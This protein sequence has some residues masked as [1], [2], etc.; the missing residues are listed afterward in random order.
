LVF[1]DGVNLPS[2]N[3]NNAKRSPGT[4][5]DASYEVGLD[6]KAEETIISVC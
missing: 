5:L 2:E 1:V 6:A 4:L 3:V